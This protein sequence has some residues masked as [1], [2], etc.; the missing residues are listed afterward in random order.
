M[1]QPVLLKES[2][3]LLSLKPGGTYVDGT[4]GSGGHAVAI[5]ERIGP[6]GRLLAIDR[7]EEALKRARVRLAGWEKQCTWAHGNYADVLDIAKRAGIDRADGVLLDL[8]VSQ[9]Q[10]VTPERGFSFMVDGPLDMRMDKSQGETAADIVNSLPE[11]DLCFLLKTLG[12]E[13]RARHIARAIAREREITPIATTLQ[14]AALVSK[15]SGGRRGRIHPATQTFQALRMAA[16]QELESLEKGL[17]GALELLSGGGRLA[18][19]SFHSLEDRIVKKFFV[20]HAGRWESL[21]AGGRRR[22]GEQPPVALI[23][24][25]PVMAS[26]EERKTNPCARSAKLR[27][28][29]KIAG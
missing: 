11:A 22:I 15:A 6:S 1:H 26:E 27:V 24:R 19:I 17:V 2:L 21:Q 28:A 18:V 20:A 5:V 16:N 13:P 7:D 10:L 8:G 25:K 23:N 29:E 12:E 14:L 9:D 3:D 4:V